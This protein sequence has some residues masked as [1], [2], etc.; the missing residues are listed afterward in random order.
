MPFDVD[1]TATGKVPGKKKKERKDKRKQEEKNVE[2][3]SNPQLQVCYI[4]VAP[5]KVHNRVDDKGLGPMQPIVASRTI[6][7]L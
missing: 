4:F 6:W 5:A 7:R 3:S 1:S 2:K